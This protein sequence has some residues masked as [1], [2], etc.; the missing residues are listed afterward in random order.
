MDYLSLVVLLVLEHS[1]FVHWEKIVDFGIQNWVKDPCSQKSF[2]VLLV[3]EH[4]E[5]VQQEEF[6]DFVGAT[7]FDFPKNS[8]MVKFLVDE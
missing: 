2:L 8:K 1:E 7:E 6:G 3:L 4:S 5:F